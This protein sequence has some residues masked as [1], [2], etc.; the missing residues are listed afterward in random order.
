MATLVN[1]VSYS[2]VHITFILYGVPVKGIT[3]IA[4]KKK[5]DKVNNYGS[6]P[7][8]V[9]R[10]VGRS[11]YEAS[12][13]LYREEWQRI[14]DISPDKDPTNIPWQDVPVVFGGSRVTAKTVVLQAVEFLEDAFEAN[15]GDTSLKVTLPLIIGGFKNI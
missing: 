14:I 8:P 4:W 12:I 11:E 7:E 1:G 5:S 15:E 3:K 2:W 9:S 6:G 13:E 10:G